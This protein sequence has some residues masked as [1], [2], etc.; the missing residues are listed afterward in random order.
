MNMPAR[1]S[2]SRGG[3]CMLID[4]YP[5]EEV[6]ARVPELAEQTDPVLGQLDRLLDDDQLDEPVRHD[7]ARRSR[8]TPVHGRPS[9]PVEGLLR[10]LVVE[11]L[12][13]WSYEETVDRVAD[14]LV[15]R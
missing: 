10:L 4:R 3:S 2:T 14:S 6:F 15:L 5:P 9:T 12:D 11:H 7:L 8:L 13:A 1:R